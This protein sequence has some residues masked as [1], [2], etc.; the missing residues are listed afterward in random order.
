MARAIGSRTVV[1]DCQIVACL[2][3]RNR[4]D[5]NFG[6][7]RRNAKEEKERVRVVATKAKKRTE[8]GA[9]N[10]PFDDLVD[11]PPLPPPTTAATP[12]GR[13][14]NRS[15]RRIVHRM[16]Y[17]VFQ[18]CSVPLRRGWVS[19]ELGY[20]SP[21]RSYPAACIRVSIPQCRAQESRV[22]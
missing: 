22:A 6:G 16:P 5:S 2:E 18:R 11:D 1:G 15:S 7:F 21:E 13:P 14:K 10:H 4:Y 8:Q 20:K 3:F 12:R 19:R 9:M 17:Q